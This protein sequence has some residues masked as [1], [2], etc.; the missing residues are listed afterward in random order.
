M[1]MQHPE[2]CLYVPVADDVDAR[3]DEGRKEC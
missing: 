2:L 3:V 1:G